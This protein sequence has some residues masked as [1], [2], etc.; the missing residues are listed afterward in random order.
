MSEVLSAA[1]TMKTP[2]MS[3]AYKCCR[4]MQCSK[5]ALLTVT[6]QKLR[7]NPQ[8][9]SYKRRETAENRDRVSFDFASDVKFLLWVT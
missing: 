4:V 6:P 8:S 3:L 7:E 5:D 9:D 2:V 1:S